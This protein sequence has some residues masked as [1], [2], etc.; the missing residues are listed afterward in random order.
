VDSGLTATRRP[1][2]GDEEGTGL[3]GLQLQMQLHCGGEGFGSEAPARCP[4]PAGGPVGFSSQAPG[5]CAA[6]QRLALVVRAA[7][8]GGGGGCSQAAGEVSSRVHPPGVAA[9][10]PLFRVNFD[11]ALDWESLFRRRACVTGVFASTQLA[12]IR[13]RVAEVCTCHACVTHEAGRADQQ[14]LWRVGTAKEGPAQSKQRGLQ[15]SV[16]PLAQLF[17][18]PLRTPLLPRAWP[19]SSANARVLRL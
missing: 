10:R 17:L 9:R 1:V 11:G 14:W 4:Q 7:S 12:C 6:V 13:Q 19:L 18:A 15:Q 5:F 8:A 3:E 16:A 2:R